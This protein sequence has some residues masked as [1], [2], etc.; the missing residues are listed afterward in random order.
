M[1]RAR[2]ERNRKRSWLF[3]ADSTR[4]AHSHFSHTAHARIFEQK[5]I[6]GENNE[7]RVELIKFERR[8]RKAAHGRKTA[9]RSKH[10]NQQVGDLCDRG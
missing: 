7:R 5:N 6:S 2:E 3:G 8:P 1:R 9:F 10:H 4:S